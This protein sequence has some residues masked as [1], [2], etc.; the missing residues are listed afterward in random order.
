MQ[1]YPARTQRA[2]KTHN[3]SFPG[4]LD[5][6]LLHPECKL[7][8]GAGDGGPE[9]L[10][11]TYD[12]LFQ[13]GFHAMA[14]TLRGVMAHNFW[15]D[16]AGYWVNGVPV[17]EIGM[18]AYTA[19]Q[20]G[21]P[22]VFVIGDRAA[23]DEARARVPGV[24]AA[25]VKEGLAPPAAGLSVAPMISLAP[26]KARAVIREGARRAMAKVEEIAPCTLPGPYDLRVKFTEAR[27][28]DHY[29]DRPGVERLDEVTVA[30]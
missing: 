26:Q 9:G 15:G 21:V 17:G 4:G 13:C 14:G 18:N 23:A 20:Y 11:V 27:F 1:L 6:E 5:V 7:V 10:D 28:A 12:A 3:G 30:L 8:M 19:G 22:F 24:E 2:G 29:A 25:V 16:I